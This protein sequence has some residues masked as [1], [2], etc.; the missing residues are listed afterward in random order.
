M[1]KK[2]FLAL[3]LTAAISSSAMAETW[4]VDKTHSSVSF[5]IR[6]MVISNVKGGFGEFSGNIQF[7]GKNITKGSVDF[8]V[9]V[10][11]IDTDDEGRDKHLKSDEFFDAAKYPKIT[12]KSKKVIA[13]GDDYK[14]IGDFTMKGIT[15]EVIFDL[16]YSGTVVDPW[17]NTRAGFAATTTINRQD[18]KVSYSKVLDNGGL[19]VGNDVKI[20]LELEIVK[21]KDNN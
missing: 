6:H 21:D 10:A 12:F 19:M 16:E 2:V 20:E 13:D 9:D 14:L 11:S 8:T 15:K 18:F 5:K 17:K 7:D 4:K 3:L 1:V